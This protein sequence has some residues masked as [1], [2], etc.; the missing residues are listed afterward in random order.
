[1]RNTSLKSSKYKLFILF[2]LIVS[3]VFIYALRFFQYQV[4]D[5][6]IISKRSDRLLYSKKKIKAIRGEIVDR[7]GGILAFSKKTYNLKCGKPDKDEIKSER[8]QKR[9]KRDLEEIAKIYPKVTYDELQKRMDDSKVKFFYILEDL[10]QD[11]ARMLAGIDV[12]YFSIDTTQKRIHPNGSLAAKIIGNINSDGIGVSGIEKY[13]ETRLRGVDGYVESKTDMSG[14]K[15][16][17]SDE[18]LI[19]KVDGER[20]VTSIDISLQHFVESACK[21]YRKTFDANNVMAIVQDSKTGEILAMADSFSYD[22]NNPME[23]LDES[24]KLDY[25]MAETNEKKTEVL[26]KMWKN[27]IVSMLYEP[28]SVM[29]IV[30]ASAA[31]DEKIVDQD[32]HY[33]CKGY[34]KL[35]GEQVKCHTFPKSHGGL[36]FK[37]GFIKSCNVVFSETVLKMEKKKYY[38]YLKKFGLL[39]KMNVELPMAEK[40][41][42]I[43]EHKLYEIDRARMSFGH[44]ISISPLHVANIAMA[45]SNQGRIIPPRTV[46]QVGDTKVLRGDARRAISVATSLEVLDYMRGVASSSPENLVVPGYDT[47]SKTGTSIKFVNGKYD[48]DTRTSSVLTIVPANNPKVNVIAIVDEPKAVKSTS[49]TAGVVAR[50]IALEAMR[51]LKVLPSKEKN[52]D[53][54]LVP[55][56]IGRTKEKAEKLAEIKGLKLEI[57]YINQDK[58]GKVVSQFPIKGTLIKD[59]MVVKLVIR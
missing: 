57:K 37:D 24:L 14:R 28:G 8:V 50:E 39:T 2:L 44:S 36:S 7:N 27:P 30:T 41:F 49:A 52:I 10:P 59:D 4:L 54:S 38:Q 40:P 5:Y 29:K 20:V 55:S 23:I 22:P 3:I 42:F 53:V 21:D 35:Y 9:I 1:M 12:R 48:R 51:S 13:Y 26:Y 18:K 32:S 58:S 47:A 34:T 33:N 16:A 11:V 25:K 46:T 17:F 56:F 6:D 31:L 45:V 43:P 19:K 15:D